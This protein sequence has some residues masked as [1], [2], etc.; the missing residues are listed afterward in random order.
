MT[1]YFLIR[2]PGDDYQI[3][4]A[5]MKKQKGITGITGVRYTLN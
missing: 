3:S 4:D 5:Q 2:K 1:H